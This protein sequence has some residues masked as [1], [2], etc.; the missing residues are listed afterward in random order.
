MSEKIKNNVGAALRNK[1]TPFKLTADLIKMYEECNDSEKKE[2]I[3]KIMY[4]SP[5]TMLDCIDKILNIIIEY[6]LDDI[7]C[8]D[9]V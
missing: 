8:P 3:L 5:S 1:L 9:D 4:K 2:I 7:I 6:K